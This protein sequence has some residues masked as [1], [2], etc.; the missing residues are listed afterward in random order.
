M[1]C[2]HSLLGW[3]SVTG[4]VSFQKRS[5]RLRLQSRHRRLD[6]ACEP[7]A[8]YANGPMDVGEV[9]MGSD[10][11]LYVVRIPSQ[12]SGESDCYGCHRWVRSG[13]LLIVLFIFITRLPFRTAHINLEG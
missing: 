10:T 11:M 7:A 13:I 4:K 6:V 2:S 5:V 3:V 12:L 9:I 1:S 8:G